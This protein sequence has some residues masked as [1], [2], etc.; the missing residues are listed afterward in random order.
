MSEKEARFKSSYQG[1]I[2]YLF[3]GTTYR[4]REF[5]IDYGDYNEGVFEREILPSIGT[6][7]MFPVTEFPSDEVMELFPGFVAA[8]YNPEKRCIETKVEP[9]TLPYCQGVNRYG[10]IARV[11]AKR[12]SKYMDM[13]TYCPELFA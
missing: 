7:K 10:R 11:A 3:E 12:L 2:E 6:V 8:R 5:G 13:K 1:E 9:D 4:V